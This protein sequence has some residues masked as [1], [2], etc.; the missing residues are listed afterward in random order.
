MLLAP[1]RQPGRH[2]GT[3]RGRY[4]LDNRTIAFRRKKTKTPVIISFSDEFASVLKTFPKEGPPFPS[5]AKVQ[6]KDRANEFRARC[7]S[8]V[9]PASVCIAIA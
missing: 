1:W 3:A 2:R 6:A 5:L 9:S 8:S 4:R 7:P